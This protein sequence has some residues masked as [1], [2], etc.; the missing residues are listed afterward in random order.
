MNL[1]QF[2][3]RLSREGEPFSPVMMIDTEGRVYAITDVEFV[4]PEHFEG[5]PSESGSGTT[6]VKVE[7]R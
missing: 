5:L 7:E 6:W 3:K 2:I 1:D 4:A